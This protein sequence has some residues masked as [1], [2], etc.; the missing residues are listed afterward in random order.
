MELENDDKTGQGLGALN[1]K[2]LG[3]VLSKRIQIPMGAIGTKC[4]TY[5]DLKHS[6]LNIVQIFNVKHHDQVYRVSA[7]LSLLLLMEFYA[8]RTVLYH[9]I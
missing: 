3:K 5:L 6:T 9:D 1:P 2:L 7:T 8:L 4:K